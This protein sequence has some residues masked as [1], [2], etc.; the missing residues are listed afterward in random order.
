MAAEVRSRTRV[1]RSLALAAPALALLAGVGDSALGQLT[2]PEPEPENAPDRPATRTRGTVELRLLGVNDFHG[3]LESPG[4][5]T[6]DTGERVPV[7][8]AAVLASHFDKA[9]A[10]FRGRTIRVHAGDMVGASP[11]LSSHFHDEPTVQAM[12][13]M[14]FDVGTLGNH[15]FDEGAGEAMRLLRGGRRTDGR[16]RKRDGRGRLVNT[17]QPGFRGV[18]F[19]YIAANTIDRRGRTLLPPTAVVEREGVKVGFIGVTTDTTPDYLL[20]RHGAGLRFLDISE[21][22]NRYVPRLRSQGVGTIVVLAHSGAHEL[23]GA[24][25]ARGEIVDEAGEMSDDVDVIVAGHTH[26]HLNLEVPDRRGHGTKLV[27]EALSFGTAYDQVDLRIDRRTGAVVEKSARTPTTWSDQVEPDPAVRDLVRGYSQRLGRL[28][29][30]VLGRAGRKMRRPDPLPGSADRGLSAFVADAQRELARADI[31]FVNPGNMRA[32]LSAGPVTYQDLFAVAPFE[33]E[34]IR[35]EMSGAD[36]LRLVDQQRDPQPSVWLHASGLRRAWPGGPAV[37]AN[38]R[39]LRPNRWYAVAANEL[40]VGTERFSAF[41]RAR[42]LRS[43]GTD[44][45]ALVGH[46]RRT[47]GPLDGR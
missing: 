43:V 31:A 16:E 20:P 21:T 40:L 45:E 10:G 7:G 25:A 34:V 41:R 47:R 33:H 36:I 6:R 1:T 26:N 32:N 28:G 35:M 14:S 17:S 18:G 46:V 39:P 15:E 37:L 4:S 9:S 44:L 19:P 27:V 5:R 42:Q 2:S 12:N 8:G 29:R 30:Q 24:S 13:L 3:H 11:L 23:R 22:V 38:G